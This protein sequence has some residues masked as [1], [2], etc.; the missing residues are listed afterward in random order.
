[1]STL[2]Q[3]P[4][5]EALLA[6]C[7]SDNAGTIIVQTN[8]LK[9]QANGQTQS[10]F[11]WKLSGVQPL[12]PPHVQQLQEDYPPTSLFFQRS[13]EGWK[14]CSRTSFCCLFHAQCRHSQGQSTGWIHRCLDIRTC[15]LPPCQDCLGKQKRSLVALIPSHINPSPLI[16]SPRLQYRNA[17][18]SFNLS[19]WVRVGLGVNLGCL[20]QQHICAYS[21]V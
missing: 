16:W 15:T 12:S 18:K 21:C 10:I 11:N 6:G 8:C 7:K 9:N 3:L 4:W 14:H 2:T 20:G 1:M 19:G 13:W 5:Q 17:F